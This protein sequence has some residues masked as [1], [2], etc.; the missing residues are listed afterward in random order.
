MQSGNTGATIYAAYTPDSGD[1]FSVVKLHGVASKHVSASKIPNMLKNYAGKHYMGHE[2][3]MVKAQQK[4]AHECGFEKIIAEEWV[5]AFR[6]VDPDT[7]EKLQVVARACSGSTLSA[8]CARGADV[9][10]AEP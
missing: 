7:G 5:A 6:A 1:K 2:L 9:G 8:R 10:S 3:A 4:L